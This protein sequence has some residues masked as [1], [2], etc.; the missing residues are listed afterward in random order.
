LVLFAVAATGFFFVLA[1]RHF[2]RHK[3]AFLFR[4]TREWAEIQGASLTYG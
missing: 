1:I 4:S 3:T 2:N